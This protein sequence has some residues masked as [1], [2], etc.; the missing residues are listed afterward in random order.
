MLEPHELFAAQGYPD[1][2]LF[3]HDC[4][5]KKLSKAKQVARCGNAVCPPVAEALVESNL[6]VIKNVAA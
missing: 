1:N 5:G 4:T 3:S 2:Y 6:F